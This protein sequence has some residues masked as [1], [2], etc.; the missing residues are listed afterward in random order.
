[1]VEK[2]WP[3]WSAKE[4]LNQN[5]GEAQMNFQDWMLNVTP[6]KIALGLLL[7]PPTHQTPPSHTDIP[8]YFAFADPSQDDL[9]FSFSYS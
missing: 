2:I 5:P 6:K 3:A 9:L 1:M 4:N 7:V 8:C